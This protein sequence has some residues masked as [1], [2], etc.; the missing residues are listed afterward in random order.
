MTRWP[1]LQVAGREKGRAQP[2]PR[3]YWQPALPGKPRSWLSCPRTFAG[4]GFSRF[5]PFLVLRALCLIPLLLLVLL[6]G[7]ALTV[8]RL[9]FAAE[10]AALEAQFCENKDKPELGCHAQCFLRHSLQQAED[11]ASGLQR[12]KAA[13]LDDFFLPT[14]A[15]VLRLAA[16]AATGGA[17]WRRNR[18]APPVVA[19]TARGC[20]QPPETGRQIQRGV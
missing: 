2:R 7:L 14:P 20:W 10:R 15:L 4:A 9:D 17:A 18:L 5:L 12:R 6:H 13:A 1:A 8:I 19:G 11:A 16:D 3:L